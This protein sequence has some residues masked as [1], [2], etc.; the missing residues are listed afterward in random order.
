MSLLQSKTIRFAVCKVGS[1]KGFA[2]TCTFGVC[3]VA[4]AVV[5]VSNLEKRRRAPCSS[6]F[7]L[8]SGG[9]KVN[10]V[11]IFFELITEY[12]I[13]AYIHLWMNTIVTT[14]GCILRHK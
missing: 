5:R 8:G 7:V 12:T 1:G 3:I 6:D 13:Y 14:L 4:G 9:S 10:L 2:V 11:V